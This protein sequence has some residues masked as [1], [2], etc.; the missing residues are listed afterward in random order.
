VSGISRASGSRVAR[1]YYRSSKDSDF[2]KWL[3]DRQSTRNSIQIL[4]A[5]VEAIAAEFGL[6]FPLSPE[7]RLR[8]LRQLHK[9]DLELNEY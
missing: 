6:D 5:R 9:D 7:T 3:A 2:R 1:E 8:I 4:K